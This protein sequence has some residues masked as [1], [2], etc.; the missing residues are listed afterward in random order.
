MTP[1]S[2]CSS[3][4]DTALG[5]KWT[6]D[7]WSAFSLNSGSLAEK[8]L[9]ISQSEFSPNGPLEKHTYFI[10]AL[11]CRNLFSSLNVWESRYNSSQWP[12]FPVT[13]GIGTGPFPTYKNEKQLGSHW[14]PGRSL[15]TRSQW[16]RVTEI[17][18]SL[19]SVTPDYSDISHRF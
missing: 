16:P 5:L 8:H 15:R 12:P 13:R 18:G 7:Y 1:I 9:R 10:S 4:F 17:W 14:E 19:I 6:L 3:Q 11:Y 2:S